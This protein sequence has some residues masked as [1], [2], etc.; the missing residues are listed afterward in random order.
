MN[1]DVI[2]TM[3]TINVGPMFI[4]RNENLPR[5]YDVLTPFFYN[6]KEYMV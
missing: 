6:I 4:T 5:V 2:V 1:D 3:V